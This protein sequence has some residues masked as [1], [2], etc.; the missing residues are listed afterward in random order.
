MIG[1]GWFL[2]VVNGAVT[3]VRDLFKWAVAAQLIPVQIHTAL[4]TVASL[5]RGRSKAPDSASVKPVPEVH[6]NAVKP[7]VSRTPED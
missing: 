7:H 5:R 4:T 2:G 1:F 6:V 3:T